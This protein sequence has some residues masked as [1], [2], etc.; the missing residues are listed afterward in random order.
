MDRSKLDSRGF[1]VLTKEEIDK[2]NDLFRHYLFFKKVDGKRHIWTSC[3]HM[4][5]IVPTEQRTIT[6]D[7]LDVLEA[8]HGEKLKCPWCGKQVQVKDISLA[9]KRRTL[10]QAENV[11]FLHAEND[12]PLYAQ[13]YALYKSY[14]TEADL[15]AYPSFWFTS[16]NIFRPS[17]VEEIYCNYYSQKIEQAEVDKAHEPFSCYFTGRWEN[18]WYRVIGLD[19]I[20]QSQM[21][22]SAYSLLMKEDR[23]EGAHWKLIRYM[24]AYCKYP[25]MEMW[26]KLGVWEAIDDLVLREVKNAAAIDWTQSDPRKAL[27]LTKPELTLFLGGR[28]GRRLAAVAA[29]KRLKR[30]HQ[31]LNFES[32][33]N[34]NLDSDQLKWLVREIINRKVDFSKAEKYLRKFEDPRCHGGWYGVDQVLALWKDYIIMGERE[35]YDLTQEVVLFPQDL[36]AAHNQLVELGNL[37]KRIEESKKDH[38]RNIQL[39]ERM[40]NLSKRYHFSMCGYHIRQP[41][42]VQEIVAEGQALKHCV[43]GYANRHAEGKVTILFLRDDKA[44]NV[45]LVTIEMKGSKLIQIHGYRNE[46]DGSPDPREVYACIVTPWLKW[47]KAGSKRQKDG[48]PIMPKRRS[49][50]NAE[51]V[52]A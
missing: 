42:S 45:P 22:Y 40:K 46:L 1:P 21:K 4:K 51:R 15:A 10:N 50:T 35:G 30:H 3:C 23:V 49:G 26:A 5:D 48:T 9:K 12:G 17:K 2:A 43:A 25:V 8:T 18:E 11:V 39:M 27:S 24:G 32:I 29:Y 7:E 13:S 19:A 28:K 33:I 38:E 20:S 31:K 16:A 37:R 44:P 47:V 6:A 41:E 36:F 34:L 52:S 14:E